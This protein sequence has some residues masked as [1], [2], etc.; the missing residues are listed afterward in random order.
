MPL[1][2][3]LDLPVHHGGLYCLLLQTSVIHLEAI[4][5]GIL[6]FFCSSEL[7]LEEVLTLA[8]SSSMERT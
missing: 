6:L 1:A 2:I 5:S 7:L 3:N 8:T 4:M